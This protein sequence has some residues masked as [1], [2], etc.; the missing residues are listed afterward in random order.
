VLSVS[1]SDLLEAKAVIRGLLESFGWKKVI[2]LGGI[3]TARGQEMLMPLW[4]SLWK[5]LGTTQFNFALVTD[6][7]Q[8]GTKR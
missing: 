7:E 3:E 1:D 5:G 8:T 6:E 2:D 4:L